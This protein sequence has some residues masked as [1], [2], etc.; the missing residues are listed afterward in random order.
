MFSLTPHFSTLT[1]RFTMSHPVT[2][3]N[4]MRQGRWWNGPCVVLAVLG[5]A[6]CTS[7]VA[8]QI[9]RPGR[10]SQQQLA[11]F[12]QVLDESGFDYGTMHTRQG[13]RIAYWYGP[14]RDYGAGVHVEEHRNR[15]HMAIH[16]KF[17]FREKPDHARLLPARGSVVL[18]HPWGME[19]SAMAAWGLMFASAGYVAVMPDLRSQGRSG[20]A[21]V[22]YG[23]REATDI[24]D[25]MHALRAEHRLPEPLYLLGASYG[26]TVAL[27]AAPQLPEVRGVIALE[28][29]AD[30]VAVIHRAPASGLFGYRWLARWL[31]PHEM[32]MAIARASRKLGVNLATLDPGDALARTSVCTLILRGTDD[33]LISASAMRALARRSSRARY[34]DVPGEGHLSLPMRT[35]RLIPPLLKWINALPTMPAGDCPG[36]AALPSVA[37]PVPRAEGKAAGNHGVARALEARSEKREDLGGT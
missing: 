18:L 15:Q 22:G 14:P 2:A 24:V 23:P 35:D 25:L 12:R 3:G 10:A 37:A 6:G 29:Y 4:G 8:R 34:V 5:L 33:V 1:P 20:N 31:S 28:P 26:A 21:P 36:Y 27:F 7:F 13:V 19:G 30:A 32:D 11:T 16:A 9:E 17:H